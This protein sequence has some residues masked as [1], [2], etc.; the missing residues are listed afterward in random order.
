VANRAQQYAINYTGY[1]NVPAD[2]QYTFYLSSDDGSTLYIDGQQIVNN[3]GLHAMIQQSNSIGLQA[4]FHKISVG[5]FQCTGD[6]GLKVGYSGPGISQQQI[7]SSALYIESNN[8]LLPAV[9]L[10]NPV[11]GMNYSY[12]EASNYSVVPDF[13]TITPVKTGMVNNFDISVANRSQQYAINYS[14]YINVPADGQYTFYL[15][16]DD[17]S[18]LYIDGQQ[19]VN[20]DG[21]HAMI[22]QSNSIGLQ[23]GF[24]KISVGFFQ[25]TGDQGLKVSY[26]GLGISQQQIPSSALYVAATGLWPAVNPSNTTNGL[27]YKYYEAA[28]FYKVPDFTT[29][30]PVKTGNVNNF[31]ISVANRT[32]QF[33]INY[34]GYI[35]V[36]TDG[37]YTFYLSSDD[38]SLLFIDGMQ[39]VNNDGTHMITEQGNTIGLQAGLHAISVGYFNQTGYEGLQV[40][41]SG[42]GI[43]KQLIPSSAL[44][45]VAPQFRNGNIGTNATSTNTGIDINNNK[46]DSVTNA[47]DNSQLKVSATAYP[48]P[49][50]N[51]IVVSITGPS[52]TYDLILVDAL[53]RTIWTGTGTKNVGTYQQTINTSSLERGIYFLKVIQSN[54]NNSAVIK[55]VK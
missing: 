42:P 34:T 2:G 13:T 49:F 19:I 7:P 32:L 45:R 4:G 11:N 28:N 46:V 52:G 54:N 27:D 31:D 35:K 21:L 8:K 53:G 36:P 55:L 18:T 41:Y 40:S 51:S 16:S 33:A 14:G 38:G 1:I 6:Q 47:L 22:Q 43:S 20:N 30:N 44:Y 37:Q 26:S 48:N 12:Y 24:H 23:A 29:M 3:D 25:C 15:S 5:F 9:N 50:T 39:V 17:G 10:S